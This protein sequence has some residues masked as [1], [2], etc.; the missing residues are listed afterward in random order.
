MLAG[1]TG[2]MAKVA[3]ALVLAHEETATAKAIIDSKRQKIDYLTKARE[4]N[5]ANPY[6]FAKRAEEG[7]SEIDDR[8]AAALPTG[9]A[10]KMYME[11]AA[12]ANLNAYE[13]NTKWSISRQTD[14]AV[15]RVKDVLEQ[16]QHLAFEAGR[17]GNEIS[18][19]SADVNNAI[20]ASSRWIDS[21]KVDNL[22]RSSDAAV[23]KNYIQGMLATEDEEQAKEAIE[24][25]NGEQ[26]RGLDP[27][28]R[29]ALAKQAQNVLNAAEIR[30]QKDQARKATSAQK[31]GEAVL[32]G[33]GLNA[34]MHFVENNPED[35][36]G[37]D[38]NDPQVLLETQRAI[39]VHENDLQIVSDEQASFVGRRFKQAKSIDDAR[40]I[41][42]EFTSAFKTKEQ[43]E[44]AI[45]NLI[46]S[47]EVSPSVK[48]IVANPSYD[49]YGDM[50]AN[51]LLKSAQNPKAAS[52]AS[53]IIND[54]VVD[55]TIDN[56]ERDDLV[57]AGIEKI[58]LITE[59]H[60]K[61]GQDAFMDEMY[62]A[63]RDALT[64]GIADLVAVKGDNAR[65]K[66]VEKMFDGFGE[67]SYEYGYPLKRELAENVSQSSINKA[68]KG[69]LSGV[70]DLAIKVLDDNGR[71][72]YMQRQD[73]PKEYDFYVKQ[74][75]RDPS[76]RYVGK[77]GAE[78]VYTLV[79]MFG[80]DVMRSNGDPLYLSE[81]DILSGGM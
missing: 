13:Q 25:I 79:D 66:D 20:L 34:Y 70:S 40:A 46:D 42:D 5:N 63:M 9:R 35:M 56:D 15:D 62:P 49:Q 2:Q 28:S 68:I 38:I 72:R 67:Y 22:K 7:L 52:Q 71:L 41:V 8:F 78:D 44:I 23:Y 43:Q 69:K 50:L 14:I 55:G 80:S 48:A 10:K 33:E 31:I 58:N 39:G 47:S 75:V 61:T 29:A 54:A 12:K 27:D 3:D 45:N 21:E 18:G 65:P 77:L 6:D 73:S 74:L 4:E 57:A 19:V 64:I 1:A 59:Y 24:M 30:R 76:L 17:A 60:L 53:K 32:K 36:S 11:D 26:G 37:K 51:G 81:R 16:G